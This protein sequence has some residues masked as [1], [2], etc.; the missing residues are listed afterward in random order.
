MVIIHVERSCHKR[1]GEEHNNWSDK[2]FLL[3]DVKMSSE[4]VVESKSVLLASL[5][6]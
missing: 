4:C 5:Y 2:C 3:I 6:Y 1:F